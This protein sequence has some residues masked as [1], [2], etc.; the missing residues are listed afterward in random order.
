MK[1]GYKTGTVDRSK[2]RF[3]NC[4][5]LGHFATECRKPKQMKKPYFDASRK[6][7][8]GNAY[9]AE[10]KSWDDTDDEE[11]EEYGNLALM[12]NK[13]SSSSA[14][15]QVQFTD[16]QMIYHLSSTLDCARRENDRII[17]ENNEL[18]K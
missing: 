4:N 9:V 18:L 6:K 10:G 7:K 1:D 11:E 8:A 14:T 3:F 13:S 16:T 2:I 15:S 5:E 17:L 12:A